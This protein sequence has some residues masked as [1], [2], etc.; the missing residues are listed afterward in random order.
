MI[1]QMPPLIKQPTAR[2]IAAKAR[3]EQV[4]QRKLHVIAERRASA[5]GLSKQQYIAEIVKGRFRGITPE[6]IA[7]EPDP[8]EPAV[9]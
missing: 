6:D 9:A 5:Q 4:K 3:A 8:G 2:S 7:A 1:P